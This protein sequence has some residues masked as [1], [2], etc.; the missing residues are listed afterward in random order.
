MF[1]LKQRL[2]NVMLL[3]TCLCVAVTC[4]NAQTNSKQFKERISTEIQ[5]LK[6]RYIQWRR[7]IH[8]YPELGN[9]E[10]RTAKLIADHLKQLG[11]EVQENVAKTG[12]VGILRGSKPGPCIG[13][14]A[15]MD[16]LPIQENTDLP[17]A[18]KERSVY[19]GQDVAV[20]HACGHDNHVAILM[21]VAEI[22]AG[23]KQHLRGIV[24]FIFQPAEESPPDGEEG[25][26]EL[27]IKEG[28]MT[29]PKVDVVFGL[30]IQSAIEIG[31]IQFKPGAFMASSDWFH[32]TV[33]GK[34]SH[35]S[36]PWL[37]V[38]PIAVSAQMIEGLQLIVSRQSDLTR[39]PVVITVGKI[40]GGV[41]TNIIPEVCTMGGTI[42][43]LDSTMQKDVHK[44]VRQV[45]ANI[46]RANGARADVTIETKAPITYNSV[47]LAKKM[48]P[49]LQSAAGLENVSET[50]WKTLA[51]DFSFYGRK[52]P[53]FFFYI[54][55]MPKGNDPAKA[56]P[57]HTAEFY[58]DDDGLATGIK[59]FCYLVFDFMYPAEISGNMGQ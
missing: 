35:G 2:L 47:E 40:S 13:L 26:A 24:K 29:D 43:T 12:V 11:M 5:K 25:G 55:G 49:S 52:A 48:I 15:D 27:M 1:K 34:G 33:T 37:G 19:N 8:Q 14:R 28:I 21:S 41:R 45:V 4:V 9:R 31:K 16:A 53:S 51:E 3:L 7:T 36:Q 39:G 56:P 58:T 38:D 54:G 18:S 59:A 17:F 42:R 50:G 57:H 46:A 10:F 20:M 30:H 44:K 23:L 22:L 6:S 32:I